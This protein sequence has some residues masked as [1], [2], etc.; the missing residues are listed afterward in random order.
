MVKCRFAK[1]KPG[2]ITRPGS[3]P[4]PTATWSFGRMERQRPFKSR[5]VGS[6]PTGSTSGLVAQTVERV[7]EEHGVGGSIPPR[8]TMPGQIGQVASPSDCKSP[9]SAVGVQL[10]PLAPVRSSSRA[11]KAIGAPA[12]FQAVVRSSSLRIA[13][14]P[15]L[16]L[17]SR[18]MVSRLTLDQADVGSSPT[19][20]PSEIR[21]WYATTILELVLALRV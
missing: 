9:V 17:P 16:F 14:T 1:P 15:L 2:L 5:D 19:L 21:R 11:M 7:S 6:I 20:A 3:N 12:A 4:G 8:S 13:P 18:L 10:P